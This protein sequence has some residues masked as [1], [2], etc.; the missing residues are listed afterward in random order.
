LL[1]D[2]LEGA[3]NLIS[4]PLADKNIDIFYEKGDYWVPGFLNGVRK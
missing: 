1:E 3:L 2:L 4:A